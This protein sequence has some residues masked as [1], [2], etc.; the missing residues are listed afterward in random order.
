[1][2]PRP[3]PQP[4]PAPLAHGLRLPSLDGLLAFE[5]AARLGTFERAADALC[6]T[7]SAV[8]KRVAAVEQLLGSALF[9]RTGKALQPT[10][11]GKEYLAQVAPIL[12]QLAALPLHQR[13]V[14]QLQRLR[15][16]A[17]PTF[18]R[19]VLVPALDGFTRLHPSVELEVLLSVPYADSPPP[20]EADLTVRHGAPDGQAPV[21]MHDR[22]LPLAAPALLARLG[23]LRAPAD[24]ARAPLLR[25]PIDP[26]APW[27]Q[28]AGLAWPEPTSGPRL[29]DLGLTLEAAAAGQGVVLARPALARAWLA[30]GAL[31]P[32][33]ALSATPATQYLLLRAPG[34]PAAASTCADWL[35]AVC[36]AQAQAAEA[37]LQRALVA[38]G[39]PPLA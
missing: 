24:L 29:L 15:L 16:C 38:A 19:Q 33:F 27:F 7:A 5:A 17:P 34:A 13:Q 14:Q 8:A 1:M 3:L 31:L 20:P 21:L 28:A 9:V 23:P 6:I 18:A 22:L 32:L 35:A 30:S 11:T 12:A 26:W 10:A 25:T 4:L 37:E 36:L 39:L 2:S